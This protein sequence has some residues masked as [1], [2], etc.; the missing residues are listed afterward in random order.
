MNKVYFQD[1]ID[2]YL[3]KGYIDKETELGEVTVYKIHDK[4]GIDIKESGVKKDPS[5][6]KEYAAKFA[7]ESLLRLR[8]NEKN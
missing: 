8:E 4:F 6:I 7:H 3:I 2:E 5:L 1:F